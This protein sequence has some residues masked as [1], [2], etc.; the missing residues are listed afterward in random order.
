MGG[1]IIRDRTFFF[2]GWESSRQ[3]NANGGGARLLTRVPTAEQRAGVFRPARS[4]IRCPE[5]LFP[6]N[7]IPAIRI[8]ATSKSIMDQLI[9]AAELRDAGANNFQAFRSE[10]TDLDMYTVRIDHRFSDKMT[11]NGRW[12][13]SFQEDLAPFGRGL[14]GMGNLSNR[15]KHTWGVTL[16]RMFSPTFVMEV[17]ASGDYTDQYTAGE[18]KM[19]PA[20]LGLK[21][22]RRRDLRGIRSRAAAHSDPQLHWR[23]FRQL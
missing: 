5:A 16:T 3:R 7:T 1:K 18:S 15:E 4:T 20:S 10:P 6:N 17:R 12:F 2:G 9:P 23:Q 11:L 13:E 8:N 22:L 19:D 14:P 21:P